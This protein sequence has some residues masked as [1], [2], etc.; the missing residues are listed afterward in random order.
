MAELLKRAFNLFVKQYRLNLIDRE[1]K[2]YF[3]IERNLNAQKHFVNILIDKYEKTHGVSLRT[4]KE[5]RADF[6]C[7][8]CTEWDKNE[9][10]CSHWYGFKEND[11]CSYG[12]PKERGGEK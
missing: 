10:E 12:T 2:R 5:K 9:C 6:T 7:K 4:P 1:C 3:D 8:D 11:F